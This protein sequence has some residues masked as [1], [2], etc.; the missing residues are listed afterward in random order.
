LPLVPAKAGIQTAFATDEAGREA[1]FIRERQIKKWNRRWRLELIEAANRGGITSRP[2]S[3][4]NPGPRLRGDER[5]RWWG[6]PSRWPAF[7]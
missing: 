1:A 6:F 4:P 5:V 3:G 7:R 2:I